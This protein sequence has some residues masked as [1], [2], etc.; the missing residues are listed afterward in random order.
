MFLEVVLAPVDICNDVYTVRNRMFADGICFF[1]F[2]TSSLL[3]D[4][5]SVLV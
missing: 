3:C 5:N 2:D 4:T 1:S